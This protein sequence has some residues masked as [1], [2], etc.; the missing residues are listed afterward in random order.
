[1]LYLGEFVPEPEYVGQI[2]TLNNLRIEL[3]ASRQVVLADAGNY[4]SGS[5]E[6][7][8]SLLDHQVVSL[9]DKQGMPELLRLNPSAGVLATRFEIAV[10]SGD[11][12]AKQLAAELVNRID[13]SIRNDA[14]ANW[15]LWPGSKTPWAFL[16]TISNPTSPAVDGK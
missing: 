3:S 15:A 5:G 8:L 14:K 16:S 6:Q 12:V 13:P 4:Y 9:R 11:P 7:W 1:M 2:N 10:I